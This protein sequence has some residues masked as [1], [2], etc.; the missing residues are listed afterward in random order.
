MVD[1]SAWLCRQT[2]ATP[3]SPSRPRS[4]TTCG[5]CPRRQTRAT[6]TSTS[7]SSTRSRTGTRCT[8]SCCSRQRTG[9]RQSRRRSRPNAF[10]WW[11]S[12]RVRLVRAAARLQPRAAAAVARR[13]Y[14]VAVVEYRPSSVATFPAQVADTRTAIR[15][16]TEHANDF[17]LDPA[18]VAL[19]GDFSGGHTVVMTAVTR[20]DPAFTD[21]PDA[22]PLDIACCVD[23]YGPCALDLMD[24]EP[25][26][27]DHGGPGSPEATYSASRPSRLRPSWYA[28]PTPAPTCTRTARCRPSSSPTAAATPGSRSRRASCSTRRCVR[29]AMTSSWSRSPVLSRCRGGASRW[30][31]AGRCPRA[32]PRPGR[33]P[34]VGPVPA[35]AWSGRPPGRCCGGP[36][37]AGAPPRAGPPRRRRPRPSRCHPRHRPGRRSPPGCPAAAGPP[38]DGSAPRSGRGIVTDL[39]GVA[40]GLHTVLDGHQHV[41]EEGVAD[42][43]HDHADRA[44]SSRAQLPR[45]LVL[46][47]PSLAIATSTRS[48]GGR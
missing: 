2:P 22:A 41:G 34:G 48:W 25:S 45:R 32:G 4:P 9:R 18:Q 16:L 31:A 47:Q 23:F 42:V 14:V 40:V 33:H 6:S 12:S 37:P 46:T 35:A 15:W 28:G 10:R 5:C 17:H 43:H 3:T 39:D 8:W 24:D 26:V 13:G 1:R 11:C 29:P 27:M 38:P 7:G 44:A 21:E 20:D 30:R 19:W 36:G